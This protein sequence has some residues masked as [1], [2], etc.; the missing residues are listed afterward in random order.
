MKLLL[1]TILAHILNPFIKVKSKHWVFSS[2]AGQMF[3]EGS[4]YL[5]M[6]MLEN[7]P[8][9][10][11]IYVVRDNKAYYDIKG[12]NYP[13]YMNLSIKGLIEILQADVVFSTQGPADIYFAFKKKGRTHYFLN[14]GQSLKVQG[15]KVKHIVD[16]SRGPVKS[17]IRKLL[18]PI[19]VGYEIKDTS[20]VSATSSF[21][22][23]F[24]RQSYGGVMPIKIL[25]MPRNDGLFQKNKMEK[26]Y[27]FEELTNKFI[28]TYMPTHR[29]FGTG[30]LAPRL[31]K[32]NKNALDWLANNNIVL[33]IKQ[34]PQMPSLEK[35]TFIDGVVI[36]ITNSG[37]DPEVIIYHSDVLISDYS[38]VWLDYLLLRRPIIHY[39]YDDFEHCDVG[40][41]INM[42][43][44][45]PGLICNNE[46]D[47]FEMLKNIKAD[48][49][50]YIPSIDVVNKFY[51]DPDG[52]S[53]ERYYREIVKEKYGFT[54]TAIR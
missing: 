9:Y 29:L 26:E 31:F 21:T 48:Y 41:N 45:A 36:D 4:K 37:I 6:Y 13:V 47:L 7:H 12:R 49:H 2:S 39:L 23:P 22:I 18:Y 33:L 46:S 3:R 15:T 14:H 10:H 5:Y 25:G 42:K 40:L 51:K 53:C 24:L 20:F 50:S 27:W 11:C 34:H 8:D 30:K 52:K 44:D 32:D 43:T 17:F 28:V 35:D 19:L 1:F 54:D 16:K 38:S